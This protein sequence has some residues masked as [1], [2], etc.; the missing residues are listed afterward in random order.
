MYCKLKYVV[1]YIKLLTN[2]VILISFVNLN[3]IYEIILSL[4]I[5]SQLTRHGLCLRN[6]ITVDGAMEHTGSMHD[7][8]MKYGMMW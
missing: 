3:L 1:I 2:F 7:T 8:K 5:F 4:N 6:E